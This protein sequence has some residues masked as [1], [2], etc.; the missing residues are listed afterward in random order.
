MTET[1]APVASSVADPFKADETSLNSANSTKLTAS[2]S[3][4]FGAST[5]SKNDDEITKP[6]TPVS[7]H[8]PGHS[9]KSESYC[10]RAPAAGSSRLSRLTS[11]PKESGE[12]SA[13]EPSEPSRAKTEKSAQAP[14][15]SAN[16]NPTGVFS[17]IPGLGLGVNAS[18]SSTSS[19]PA[20]P[21]APLA[22]LPAPPAADVSLSTASAP[23]PVDSA[24]SASKT[25]P[26]VG[27]GG[28]AVGEKRKADDSKPDMLLQD[29]PTTG[30][31]I[32]QSL[33]T[34]VED[35]DSGAESSTPREPDA[36]K[37]KKGNETATTSL[38]S[39]T[40]PVAT[41]NSSG[42]PA[43]PKPVTEK[44]DA[45]AGKTDA[46]AEK[47]E[48]TGTTETADKK[49]GRPKKGKPEKKAPAPIGQTA[50]K[51]RSQGPAA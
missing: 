3:F 14:A 25:T 21:A 51:T 36:K 20:K 13:T 37:A 22:G 42:K 6:V 9:D 31:S 40:A 18:S 17:T 41:A 29:K 49:R 28:P 10:Y 32:L 19:L 30:S 24:A 34:T 47:T 50:R 23:K 12:D 7:D 43:E 44:T 33:K 46:V 27:L 11:I 45:V 5:P 26:S 1:S 4:T 16:L 8:S 38:T 35:F 39:S 48:K 2:T 15:P